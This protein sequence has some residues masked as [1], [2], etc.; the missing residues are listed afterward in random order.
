VVTFQ[1]AAALE[2]LNDS[3]RQVAIQETDRAL[4]KIWEQSNGLYGGVPRSPAGGA[5][6]TAL[7]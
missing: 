3:M 2:G 6:N 4:A 1:G 7:A 5:G